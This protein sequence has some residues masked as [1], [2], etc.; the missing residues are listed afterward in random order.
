MLSLV[1]GG[2]AARQQAGIKGEP[3]PITA[4]EVKGTLDAARR[5]DTIMRIVVNRQEIL[6][7]GDQSLLDVMKRLPGVTGT[8]KYSVR[9]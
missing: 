6:K 2:A 9:A 7:Y 1:G 4:V 3:A 5:D 8:G